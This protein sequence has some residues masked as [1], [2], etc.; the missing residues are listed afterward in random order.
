MV[1]H[2]WGKFWMAAWRG[3][4]TLTWI[5]GVVAFIA[6]VVECFTGYLSQQNFDSQWISTSGKDATN[7]VGLGAFFNLMNV[8]Q[9]LLW[10]VVLIPIVLLALVG[11]HILLVRVHGV[12]HPLPIQPTRGRRARQEAALADAQPWRGPTRR[13]D[14]VKEATIASVIALV[15]V[16]LL[17]ALLS[18]PDA[19]PV[20]VASWAKVAPADF[21]AT[22]ASELAGSSETAT[23]GPPYNHES[24]SAQRIIVSWQLLGGVRQP[25]NA[26]QTFVLS[27]LSVLAP[28]DATLSRALVSYR[29]A[30]PTRRGAWDKAYLTAVTH[31]T[32]RS[33]S[34][35]VPTANDGPVPT[36][37]ATELTLARSGAL[38]ADLLAQHPF[39]GSDFTKPLLFL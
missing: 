31:V 36:L 17:A 34:P 14:I 12:A 29:A 24:G 8:G 4:R 20:T 35:V 33:D 32:F 25:I 38:D 22:A 15:L 21:M 13:Y 6:S 19:P 5:T 16:V 9:M 26:A 2:L 11:A 10:H 23:Y 7:A 39:Y 28:T 18:S 37:I 1:I 30:N 27:P 3:R